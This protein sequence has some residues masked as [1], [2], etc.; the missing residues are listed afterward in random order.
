M[1][2]QPEELQY[3]SALVCWLHVTAH[4]HTYCLQEPTVPLDPLAS[5][6]L[7]SRG[8]FHASARYA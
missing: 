8:L 3:F 1:L 4:R 5:Q 2:E 7:V 6:D